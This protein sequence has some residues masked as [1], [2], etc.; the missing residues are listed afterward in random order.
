MASNFYDTFVIWSHLIDT[1]QDYLAHINNMESSSK[2]HHGAG[3][4]KHYFIPRSPPQESRKQK[5]EN[6]YVQKINVYKTILTL[7]LKPLTPQN[8]KLGVAKYLYDKAKAIRSD[9]LNENQEIQR[10]TNRIRKNE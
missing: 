3:K 1:L 5:R 8:A 7:L 9:S 10:I 6:E 2:V 4:R